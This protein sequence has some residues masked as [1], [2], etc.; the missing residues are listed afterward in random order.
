VSA[1]N[2]AVVAFVGLPV[3]TAVCGALLVRALI[4]Q[5]RMWLVWLVVGVIC[6]VLWAFAFS[7]LAPP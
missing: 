3:L 4:R 2:I 5:S 6:C 1:Q 7:K